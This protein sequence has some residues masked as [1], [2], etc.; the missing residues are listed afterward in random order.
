MSAVNL[1]PGDQK[2]LLA[3]WQ[4]IEP[5]P[6]VHTL[7]AHQP[8]CPRATC[9]NKTEQVNYNTLAEKMKYKNAATA[10]AIFYSL[11]K[12]IGIETAA[13]NA[14]SGGGGAGKG[15]RQQRT[16]A[17]RQAEAQAGEDG[18]DGETVR[19]APSKRSRKR[20]AAEPADAEGEENTPAP[21]KKSKRG[22]KAKAATVQTVE[23]GAEEEIVVPRHKKA[24]RPRQDIATATAT[25]VKQEVKT[26]DADQDEDFE[27]YYGEEADEDSAKARAS[28]TPEAAAE[29]RV[30]KKRGRRS[31]PAVLA[32]ST[33][34]KEE[35][36][37]AAEDEFDEPADAV[38]DEEVTGN[39][40]E[41]LL[42]ATKESLKE[43]Q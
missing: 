32:K 18:E 26:E 27:N 6:R 30:K 25:V 38:D 34:V 21:T 13:A 29:E 35:R 10:N 23:E 9:A 19:V 11:K 24:G 1:T 2:I 5:V 4:S 39:A 17:A 28:K 14:G 37:E 20:A 7:P 15:S 40:Y 16:V 8:P 41:A 12:K 43:E 33:K 42:Q 31:K 22:K 36:D 3:A